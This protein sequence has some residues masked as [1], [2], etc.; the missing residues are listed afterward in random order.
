MLVFR[1]PQRTF[2]IKNPIAI[3]NRIIH[4]CH[5]IG[6]TNKNKP[7]IMTSRVLQLGLTE[8]VVVKTTAQAVT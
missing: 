3:L 6:F 5:H 8:G 7:L 1:A 2:T 4:N